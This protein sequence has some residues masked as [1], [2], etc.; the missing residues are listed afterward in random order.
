MVIPD[1][2]A[3][4]TSLILSAIAYLWI[5]EALHAATA[6]AL[7]CRARL[8]FSND[9]VFAAP[10]IIVEGCGTGLSKAAVLYAPYVFNALLFLAAP[11]SPIGLL[12]VLTLPNALLENESMRGRTTL[13]TA[14]VL[15][16]VEAAA[17]IRLH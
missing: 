1:M 5:H 9:G 3:S 8:G 2:L 15:L 6:V 12:A 13:A 4:L 11:R 17:L 7:G 14:M 10:S 16:A